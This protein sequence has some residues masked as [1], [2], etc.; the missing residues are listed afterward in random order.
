MKKAVFRE[1][2][3]QPLELDV[4]IYCTYIAKVRRHRNMV[5]LYSKEVQCRTNNGAI[6]SGR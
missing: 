6:C 1:R 2:Y 5:I 3:S 4:V